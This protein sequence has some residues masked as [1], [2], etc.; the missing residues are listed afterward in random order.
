MLNDYE[1]V[2]LLR[3]IDPDPRSSDLGIVNVWEFTPRVSLGIEIFPGTKYCK[4]IILQYVTSSD[5][6]RTEVFNR[7]FIS[8]GPKLK[9]REDPMMKQMQQKFAHKKFDKKSKKTR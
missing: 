5:D 8:R 6:Y 2:T 1:N 7:T 9:K 3:C 4:K